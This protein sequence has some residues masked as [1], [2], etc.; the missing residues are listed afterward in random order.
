M[1]ARVTSLS[2]KVSPRQIGWEPYV[3]LVFLGFLFMQPFLDPEF[4]PVRWLLTF[5][6]IATFLPLYLGS[7]CRGRH[8]FFN[9]IVIAL[10]GFVGMFINSG[11]SSFFIYAAAGAPFV[12]KPRQ[13][14]TFIATILS[15][16]I[17]AFGIS[18]IPL[19]YRLW[20]FFPGVVF[21]PIIG[22]INIFEAE[23]ERANA[24]LRLAHEEV[25]HLATIAERERIARD[26]HDLLGHT[27]SVITLKSELASRLVE[28]D[29]ER[30]VREMTEVT[31]VSRQALKE[32]REAVRGYRSRGLSGEL[33]VAKEM[34]AAADVKFVYRMGDLALSPTEEGTLALAL[35]E[36]IT[37]VVRHASAS[38]CTVRL[39]EVAQDVVL[40]VEDD[41]SGKGQQDGAGLTGMRER[42]E[43]LGGSLRLERLERGTRLVLTLPLRQKRRGVTEEAVAVPAPNPP[44][45][46]SA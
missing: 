35:R 21:A 32:V 8:A 14:V 23:K 22:G 44:L 10:L 39:G 1:R 3:Y 19:P 17:L 5:G 37:N 26:L 24:K 9:L 41:G 20:A 12:L 13:A 25:E 28:A 46:E 38:I 29:A 18:T 16:E 42:A 11:S 43:T 15:L 34:L 40:T 36:A 33:M 4:G 45:R 6:L 7:Y 27:L 31:K 30:A 2:A